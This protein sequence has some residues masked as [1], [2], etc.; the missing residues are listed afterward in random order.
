VPDDGKREG[1]KDE[2]ADARGERRIVDRIC[3]QT[4]AEPA[5][6]EQ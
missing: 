5:V 3:S 6:H 1:G 2:S 4:I